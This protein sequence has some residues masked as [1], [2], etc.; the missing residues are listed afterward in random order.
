[1]DYCVDYV[2]YGVDY[3]VDC[4]LTVLCPSTPLFC[5]TDWSTS[6]RLPAH[7]VLVFPDSCTCTLVL[8][9]T[10]VQKGRVPPCV[11]SS[12]IHFVYLY[13]TVLFLCK[14]SHYSLA[15]LRYG[16]AVV[17]VVSKISYASIV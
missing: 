8:Y 2:D 16:V 12:P 10:C 4:I 15:V 11:I 5:P 13:R 17:A 9:C 14:L 3:C 1:M 6:S 7:I